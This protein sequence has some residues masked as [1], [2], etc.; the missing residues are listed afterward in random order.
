MSGFVA[1]ARTLIE[2]ARVETQV[3][4]LFH[5]LACFSPSCIY[6]YTLF[7][8]FLLSR[9]LPPPSSTFH[10]NIPHFSPLPSTEPLVPLRRGYGS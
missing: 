5:H 4:L 2:H 9:S 6:A 7:F 3:C 1:D 10:T 8:S